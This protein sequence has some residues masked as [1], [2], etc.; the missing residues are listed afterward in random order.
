MFQPDQ[1]A[2]FKLRV[3]QMFVVISGDFLVFLLQEKERERRKK[4]LLVELWVF[5]DASTFA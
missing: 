1:G 4:T 3:K 2:C 5:L